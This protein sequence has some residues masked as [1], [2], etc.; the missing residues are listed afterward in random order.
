LVLIDPP[1]LGA[2]EISPP[3]PVP[4]FALFQ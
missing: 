1:V 4:E 3:L 2:I